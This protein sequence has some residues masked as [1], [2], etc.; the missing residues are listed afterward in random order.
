MGEG[1]GARGADSETSTTSP[2]NVGQ[3]LQLVPRGSRRYASMGS[4]TPGPV[5]TTE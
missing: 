5:L 4:G 1:G 2:S 3:R